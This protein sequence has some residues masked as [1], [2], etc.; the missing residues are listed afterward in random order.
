[1]LLE[2]GDRFRL[3]LE[4]HEPV[5]VLEGRDGPGRLV[6]V[7]ERLRGRHQGGAILAA[8]AGVGFDEIGH[9]PTA[10]HLPGLVQEQRLGNRAVD[11]PHHLLRHEHDR[12]QDDAAEFLAR[13]QVGQLEHRELCL[14]L[15]RDLTL[16]E[17]AVG[18]G[19]RE[20]HHR[21]GEM[22][23]ELVASLVERGDHVVDRAV[24]AFGLP[25]AV[26]R[27]V[28][29]A[30][31]GVGQPVDVAGHLVHDGLEHRHAVEEIV[32]VLGRLGG[33]DHR[34]R[35]QAEAA[36]HREL[37]EGTALQLGRVLEGAAVVD[38]DNLGSRAAQRGAQLLQG[39]RL[40]RSR[41]AEHR[42]VVVACGVLERAPEEGLPPSADQEQ[43]RRVT[44]EILALY[45][46]QVRRGRAEH[47][48]HALH[49]LEVAG[50]PVR[51]R[52]G[53]RAQEA[54]HLEV[55]VVEQVP[56]CGPVDRL[57]DALVGVSLPLGRE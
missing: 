21:D 23:G 4:D 12:G 14:Q 45:G 24:P 38:H 53:H 16:E 35:V 11:L 17:L 46:S 7:V 18:A 55:A 27:A 40:A 50:Q 41:L 25:D 9:R 26:D 22:R 52:H 49:A 54:H 39:D 34:E 20:R 13:G 51:H 48:P 32:L 1:M 47:G 37:D 3:L 43:V 10:K 8:R 33:V 44:T 19:A 30:A 28:D 57:E 42:H 2:V 6:V 5:A 56:A 15:E 36:R 31:L 29:Q